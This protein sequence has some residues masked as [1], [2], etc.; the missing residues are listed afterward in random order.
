MF[1]KIHIDLSFICFLGM[2]GYYAFKS[3]CMLIL[4]HIIGLNCPFLNVYL[5]FI[6]LYAYAYAFFFLCVFWLAL[7]MSFTYWH[8]EKFLH[9]QNGHH[10]SYGEKSQRAILIPLGQHV[11][12]QEIQGVIFFPGNAAVLQFISQFCK[13]KLLSFLF[14]YVLYSFCWHL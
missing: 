1:F 14:Y 13:W 11:N 12:L 5:L 6:I 3:I 4:I 7:A 10:E 2:F 8:G 9:K